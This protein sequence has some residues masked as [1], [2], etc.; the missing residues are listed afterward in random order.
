[1]TPHAT[2]QYAIARGKDKT[3]VTCE[4]SIKY[5]GGQNKKNEKR[6]DNNNDKTIAYILIFQSS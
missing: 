6:N 1:M 3:E 5:T 2:H 4:R